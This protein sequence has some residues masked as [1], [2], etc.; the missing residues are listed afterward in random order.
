MNN[1]NFVTPSQLIRKHPDQAPQL[2]KLRRLANK[3]DKVC[4]ICESEK[5]WKYGETGMCFS[6]TTGEYDAS[7]D[8]ELLPEE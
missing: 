5:A 1:F 2:K 7:E 8:Y 4:D 3:K 6:C